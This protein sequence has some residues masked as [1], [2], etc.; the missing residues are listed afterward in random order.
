MLQDFLN[1]NY[2]FPSFYDKKIPIEM[3]T[4][5]YKLWPY[6]QDESNKIKHTFNIVE[7]LS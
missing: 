4:N 6:E 7:L 3:H 2:H 5:I 1:T